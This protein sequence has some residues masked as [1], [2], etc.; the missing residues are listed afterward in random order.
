MLLEV[1][2][3]RARAHAQGG[4][5]LRGVRFLLGHK[6]TRSFLVKRTGFPW[7]ALAVFVAR[8]QAVAQIGA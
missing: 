3:L 2:A 5:V 1:A 4:N 8:P 6:K 7:H